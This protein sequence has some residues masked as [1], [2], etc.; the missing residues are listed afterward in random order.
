VDAAPGFAR[1]LTSLAAFFFGEVR[2]A[3]PF[4]AFLVV[5]GT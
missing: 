3:A 1:F 2:H 4:D 5:T